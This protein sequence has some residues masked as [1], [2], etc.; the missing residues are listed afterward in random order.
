[1]VPGL[2]AMGVLLFVL[3]IMRGKSMGWEMIVSSQG[4]GRGNGRFELT[5][6]GRREMEIYI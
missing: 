5:F 3:G 2:C 6:D 1:M 4:R